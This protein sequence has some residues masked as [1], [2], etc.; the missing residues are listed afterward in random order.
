MTHDTPPST[1]VSGGSLAAWFRLYRTP[2]LGARGFQRVLECFPTP[3]AFLGASRDEQLRAGLSGNILA[4]VARVDEAEV[5]K[6]LRWLESKEHHL[7]RC[8]DP[9]YPQQLRCI[10]V[11]PPM[12]FVVGKPAVL[13]QP[14]LAVVGSRNP[15][16]GGAVNAHD[17][18]A[19]L[20]RAGL[21]VTSGLALGIDA[22]AHRGALEVDGFS[23]AVM[24]TGPDRIYPAR[25]RDLAY[26]IAER[27]ALIT[28][29]PTGSG[30]RREHFPRRNR[31]IS[32]LALGTLIVEASRF[33][34]SLITAQHALDQGREVF[35][36][37]GSIHNPL[38]RGCHAL[39]RQGA[40]LV[41]SSTDVL[42][43][44]PPLVAP[45]TAIPAQ[46]TA[47]APTPL[48]RDYHRLLTALG[49]DPAPVDVLL[50]RTGL[51]PDVLSS[52][53]LQLELMG[54]VAV[55]PG[56]RYARLGNWA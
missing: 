16:P 7:L 18:A 40:K 14:Q 19:H 46:R 6:D 32:G 33:S 24:G 50:Q 20:A 51:T 8:I 34:G 17:F 52:M 42:E 31:I 30:P 26:A 38:A 39:I 44:L 12:L 11:P 1:S 2:G 23:A 22:C 27:G 3:E 13:M 41:E 45:V 48:D 55:C 10:P 21:T 25:H 36:I 4:A 35:A 56:G 9:A 28:E 43:E 47:E 29:L 54:Y 37:P 53:L 15:T 49:H 5:E